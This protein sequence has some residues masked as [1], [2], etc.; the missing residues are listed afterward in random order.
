QTLYPGDKLRVPR[1]KASQA[2]KKPRTHVV[3][4]GDTMSGVA[5]KYGVSVREIADAN[6]MGA[7]LIIRTGETL[8]IPW[9]KSSSGSSSTG[10]S[11]S[12]SSSTGS[13]SSTSTYVVKPGDTLS[14]IAAGQGVSTVALARANG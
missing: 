4:R 3:R 11:S 5:L 10:P 12:T 7:K 6:G 14:Q 9:P 2:E 13:A 1:G 8:Q